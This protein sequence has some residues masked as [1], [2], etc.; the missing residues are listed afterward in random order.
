MMR[1]SVLLP[2]AVQAQHADLGPVEE[3]Q[4][5][6]PQHL[7]V[8]GLENPPDPHHREDHLLI[9]HSIH[10]LIASASHLN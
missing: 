9:V 2:D 4:R 5:D 3:A 10:I 7:P 1:S 8:V 6:I